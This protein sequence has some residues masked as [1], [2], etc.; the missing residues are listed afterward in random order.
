MLRTW[1]SL[2]NRDPKF[3]DHSFSEPKGQNRDPPSTELEREETGF[4][5]GY[6]M[7]HSHISTS[8][9][10]RVMHL[11]K[12]PWRFEA[13]RKLKKEDDKSWKTLLQG[14]CRSYLGV[15]SL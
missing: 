9:T 4:V 12:S 2:G 10:L 1:I 11:I 13:L 8:N 5:P 7:T 3:K 15:P 6:K 14:I